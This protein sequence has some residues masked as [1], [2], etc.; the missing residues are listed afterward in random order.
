MLARTASTWVFF[1]SNDAVTSTF[2]FPPAGGMLACWVV[3][4]TVG[5]AVTFLWL[6]FSNNSCYNGGVGFVLLF[7]VAP[8][9]Q[10]CCSV[11]EPTTQLLEILINIAYAFRR[12][13]TV[14]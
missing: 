8:A 10:G 1:S 4:D 14:T 13:S 12:F 11:V 5:F 7:S 9:L 2:F 3:K 6:F